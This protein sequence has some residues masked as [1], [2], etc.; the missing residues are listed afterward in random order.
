MSIIQEL[1]RRNVFRVAVAYLAG[2]WLLV[3]VAETLFPIY[4]FSDASIRLVVTLLAIGFPLT[5]IFSWVFELTPEGLRLEKDIDTSAT[6]AHRTTKKLDRFIIVLLALALGYFAFDKFVLEPR[7]VTEIA[8]LASRA[9]AEQ[10]LDQQKEMALPDKSIAVLP[11]VNMSPDSGDTY[12]SDGLTEELIGALVK[13]NGLHVTARTSAFAFKGKNIDIREIG[14]RLNVR[15]LLEGSVRREKDRIRVT[16]QLVS[17]EDGFH[18]WSE[19]YDYELKSVLALQETISR[20]I[21]S[22]LQIQLSPRV[23]EQLRGKTTVNPEAYDLYLKG[24]YYWA[25][26]STGGFQQSIEAFQKAIAVDADYAPPHAGLATAYSFSGYFGIMPP[27]EAFPLS[28][29][30]ADIALALDPESSEALVARGMASLVFEWNWDRARDDLLLALDISPNFAMA[31]WAYTEYLGVVDPTSALD[32]ALRALSLDPLS[33]PIMNRV[34]FSYLDQGMFAD[35]IRIDEEMLAMDSHFPTA[36]WNLGIIHMFHGRFEKA[37]D[38]LSQAVEYS[39]GMPPML[40]IQAYAY[41]KSGDEA[42]AQAILTRLI[43]I[44]ESPGRGYAAPVLIAYVHE[45]LG[46][47]EDALEWLEKAIVE[48]DGWLITLNSFPRFDSLQ[49]EPRFK[50][51]L[52]RVGLPERNHNE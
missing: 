40:A 12:F 16:A 52:R 42:S 31:H 2:A 36:H 45:G 9:G 3:E 10:A 51:I 34:A 41:A 17:V 39:G 49:G 50:D 25:R 26:L 22:A 8:E 13:V 30:E 19:S 1:K 47:T 11:F 37:I 18:L 35:A 28:I 7:R 27:R 43:S 23:D 15:T 20:A 21:A 38:E 24:R 29:M 48:R 33:L 14:K 5:L 32:S 6:S 4:G 44:R 46:R